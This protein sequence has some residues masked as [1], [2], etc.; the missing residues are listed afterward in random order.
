MIKAGGK[1]SVDESVPDKE[2]DGTSRNMLASMVKVAIL[3]YMRVGGG[4]L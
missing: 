1:V 2:S 3:I 4:S